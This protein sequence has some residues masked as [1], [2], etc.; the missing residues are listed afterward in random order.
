MST[1]RAQDGS[2]A[3]ERFAPQPRPRQH[4]RSAGAPG[5]PR[6]VRHRLLSLRISRTRRCGGARPRVSSRV[7]CAAG[8]QAAGRPPPPSPGHVAGCGSSTGLSRQRF[9]GGSVRLSRCARGLLPRIG[10]GVVVVLLPVRPLALGAFSAPLRTDRA[11]PPY[12]IRGWLAWSAASR[13]SPGAHRAHAPAR[14]PRRSVAAPVP[15]SHRPRSA[16]G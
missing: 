12:P 10:A 1:R 13:P 6:W 9:P 16:A 15:G 8:A 7:R 5:A 3:R 2:P 11:R 4:T 14:S